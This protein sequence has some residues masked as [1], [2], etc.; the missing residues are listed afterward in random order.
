MTSRDPHGPRA[1]W[2][3]RLAIARDFARRYLRVNITDSIFR[4]RTFCLDLKQE[5]WQ[6]TRRQ[7]KETLEN[8]RHRRFEDFTV[9]VESF[10]L[11][12]C[13][14]TM[15]WRAHMNRHLLSTTSA[16]LCLVC[17]GCVSTGELEDSIA[18]VQRQNERTIGV[19]E[20]RIT[21]L[22]AQLAG[23]ELFALE[24][25][26]EETLAR[27]AEMHDLRNQV[28][29]TESK[30]IAQLAVASHA[31]ATGRKSLDD[32]VASVK[33]D[34]SAQVASVNSDISARVSSVKR[35]LS[36]RIDIEA[37][38]HIDDHRQLLE[39]TTEVEQSTADRIEAIATSR[40]EDRDQVTEA[41]ARLDHDLAE[42]LET[43][44]DTRE[45]ALAQLSQEM[46]ERHQDLS[47]SI[48]AA[49]R[50]LEDAE[51]ALY[52]Q[53]AESHAALLADISD[54]ARKR[55]AQAQATGRLLEQRRLAATTQLTRLGAELAGL[56][57]RLEATRLART[58]ADDK[59]RRGSVTSP[60][61]PLPPMS[62]PEEASGP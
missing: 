56:Q 31:S 50:E 54:E 34:L 51:K 40:Q 32:K 6:D 60:L 30:L 13:Q 16:T 12:S 29:E 25:V 43:E 59:S 14:T 10:E 55:N 57:K 1:G 18:Q 44:Q 22:Q 8:T 49:Q 48:A 9:P 47:A 11:H 42:R 52:T 7:A 45:L 36:A 26:E 41:I 58:S 4:D 24:T 33:R 5:S 38:V 37:M 19:L 28:R 2:S 23:A 39:K 3:R 21:A 15:L 17:V 46:R 61:S 53:L 62:P 35:D 27:E 20:H